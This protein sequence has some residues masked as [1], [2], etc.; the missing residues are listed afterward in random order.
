MHH[1]FG[2]RKEVYIGLLERLG[3]QREEQLQPPVGRSARARVARHRVALAGLDR[4]Q[5]HHLARTIAPGEDITD[6]DVRRAV[7]D[8][9]RRAVALLTAF[10]A[11]IAE[12]SPRLRHAL[13]C[14]TGSIAP[15]HDAG[16]TAKP[17]ARR[18]TN[19]SPPRLNTSS[20][21]SA[22]GG[23]ALSR[24]SLDGGE[25]TAP[26]L[27]T[28]GIATCWRPAILNSRA[29]RVRG[30]ASVPGLAPNPAQVYAATR[31]VGA[32]LRRTS[33]LRSCPPALVL[34]RVHRR[35]RATDPL[36]DLARAHADHEPQHHHL[37]LV[38]R[39]RQ[40]RFPER[41][42][43]IRCDVLARRARLLDLLVLAPALGTQ[44]ID[45]RVVRDPRDPRPE[46]G[47]ARPVALQPD[48]QPGEDR[49]RDVLRCVLV[50][51]DRA[52]VRVDGARVA[53]VEEAQRLRVS[54]AR[55][56]GRPAAPV[57]RP[58]AV[59]SLPQRRAKPA[60]PA[61]SRL[62]AARRIV[63]LMLSLLGMRAQA[64][65]SCPRSGR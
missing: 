41:V 48:R 9:V 23:S 15:R 38:L 21:R 10:H 58:A 56:L 7:A 46:R 16:C 32:A 31:T 20:E 18:H 51:E 37:A 50:A 1:Y 34:E 28:I 2:G 11:D 65:G 59:R 40:K 30:P 60:V 49:L 5:P 14:W 26:S 3:A 4:G 52:H 42:A 39:K 47:L 62:S 36:A 45:R 24:Q 63:S 57:P 22:P 43:P 53:Q 19:C 6:P 44:V 25:V 64:S 12:D 55:P 27:T 61:A 13:E 29:G 8:L 17:P 35:L 33:S 54:V